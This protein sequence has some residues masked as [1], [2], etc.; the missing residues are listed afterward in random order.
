MVT[1]SKKDF[2]LV[3]IQSFVVQKAS[4]YVFSG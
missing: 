4:K 1:A 3:L 2:Y